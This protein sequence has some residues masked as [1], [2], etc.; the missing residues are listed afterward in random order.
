MFLTSG[1]A[2]GRTIPLDVDEEAVQIGDRR[3]NSEFLDG[4][5]V[6]TL[7]IY[8]PS[9]H[10][11]NAWDRHNLFAKLTTHFLSADVHTRCMSVLE[12]NFSLFMQS[13]F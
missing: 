8:H 3:L 1:N 6:K 12:P 11:F 9:G 13:G 5:V 4:R 10:G 2:I 7:A